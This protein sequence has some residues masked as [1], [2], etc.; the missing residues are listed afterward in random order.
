MLEE[1]W[2]KRS[3][4]ISSLVSSGCFRYPN[5]LEWCLSVWL[6]IHQILSS[7]RPRCCLILDL[8]GRTK[9]SDRF[10]PFENMYSS[11][12]KRP[13][14]KCFQTDLLFVE[15]VF[16]IICRY[17]FLIYMERITNSLRLVTVAE[18]WGWAIIVIIVYRDNKTLNNNR[19]VEV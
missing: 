19:I 18:N 13:L 3:K 9:W 10:I 2:W 8:E 11:R 1:L 12:N 7:N 4:P 6:N 14:W 16:Q 17:L 15:N 5:F